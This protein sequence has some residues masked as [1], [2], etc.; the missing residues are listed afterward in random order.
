MD[1]PSIVAIV[2]GAA[3][4]FVGFLFFARHYD[5]VKGRIRHGD[6]EAGFEVERQR[7][8]PQPVRSPPPTGAVGIGGSVKNAPVKTQA[9]GTLEDGAGSVAIGGD[10]EGGSITTKVERK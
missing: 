8:D 2:V 9:S 4:V 10:V 3:I 5:A 1:T 6:S 7:P